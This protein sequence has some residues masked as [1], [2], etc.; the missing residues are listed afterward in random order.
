[1]S[2]KTSLIP[3]RGDVVMVNLDPTIGHEQG[4]Q[5][6]ALV[7]SA[8]AMNRSPAGLVIVAPI[9]GSDRG[10]PAHIKVSSPEGGLTKPSV[11]MADQIRT[12]SRRRLARRLGVVSSTTMRQVEDCL[13]LVLDL[14]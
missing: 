10:I 8:D 12:I 1:M 3:S 5:R 4:G 2:V 13:K 11:I 7:V 14:S 6:P 9:T